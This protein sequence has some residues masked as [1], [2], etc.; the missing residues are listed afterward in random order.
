MW[1]KY[2]S[3]SLMYKKSK[4]KIWLTYCKVV[5]FPFPPRHNVKR[6]YGLTLTHTHTLSRLPLPHRG[7]TLMADSLILLQKLASWSGWKIRRDFSFSSLFFFFFTFILRHE[8]QGRFLRDW[9]ISPALSPSSSVT[10]AALMTFNNRA[11]RR[12]RREPVAHC[13]PLC[14]GVPVDDFEVNVLT[15]EGRSPS[16]G[17]ILF[18]PWKPVCQKDSRLSL[19]ESLDFI[20]GQ[21]YFALSLAG[22]WETLCYLVNTASPP[23]WLNSE[24]SPLK[25][26]TCDWFKGIARHR[27]RWKM[28]FFSVSEKVS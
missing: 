26:P 6:L 23:V 20:A 9:S 13:Q 28:V 10:F 19:E 8:K 18:Q 27:S 3:S 4:K 16:W 12:A 5:I 25:G 7:A 21:L 1:E 24:K 2:H 14:P 15:Q 11:K 17:E 22:V